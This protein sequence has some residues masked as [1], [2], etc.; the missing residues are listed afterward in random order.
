MYGG[1]GHLVQT[2]QKIRTHE[3]MCTA[4][5]ICLHMIPLCLLTIWNR[6]GEQVKQDGLG[7]AAIFCPISRLVGFAI[8]LLVV[9]FY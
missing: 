8:E 4:Q 5:E 7:K 3:V 6:M 1:M 2:N 9:S